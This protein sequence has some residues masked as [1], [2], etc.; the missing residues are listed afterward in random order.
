M[1]YQNLWDPTNVVL[2]GICM[3]FNTF[4]RK[5]ERAHIDNLM[6]QLQK[7]KN[8]QQNESKAVRRNKIIKQNRNPLI[9]H[10]QNNPK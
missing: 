10:P 9:G 3:P 7:L 5:E 1:N 2:R 8:D 4:I 6:A